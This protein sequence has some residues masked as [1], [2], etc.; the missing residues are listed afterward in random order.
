M[1]G[2]VGGMEGE[3]EYG[4]EGGEL[5]CDFIFLLFVLFLFCFLM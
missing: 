2:C 5:V 4:R 1:K 3:K